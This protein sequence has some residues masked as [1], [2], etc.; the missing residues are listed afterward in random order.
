MFRALRLALAAP[1]LATLV[2]AAPARADDASEKAA[3][4]AADAWLKL[5]DA[6]KYAASWDGAATFS[7]NAVPKP[8]WQRSLEAVRAP[9]GKLLS[10]KVAAKTFT[11]SLPGAPDGKYVVLQYETSFENKKHAIETVTPMLEPDGTWRVSG[12]YV[13]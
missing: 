8:Q 5:V 13:K 1:L 11:E 7:R 10:R 4:A 6:G 3:L 9:L 2:L 12:Y